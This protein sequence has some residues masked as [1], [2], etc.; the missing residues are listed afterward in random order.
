MQTMRL[1]SI[2]GLA[3]A[4]VHL[5]GPA[6]NS[7]LNY[8]LKFNSRLNHNL[9]FQFSQLHYLSRCSRQRWCI[10]CPRRLQYG[11]GH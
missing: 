11:A 2:K 9:K 7:R 5:L 3:E 1:M 8:N 4:S 10:Q 6:V